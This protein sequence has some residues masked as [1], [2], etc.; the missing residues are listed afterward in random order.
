MAARTLS[1][2]PDDGGLLGKLALERAG[3]GGG[4]GDL[5]ERALERGGL[6]VGPDVGPGQMILERVFEMCG[7]GVEMCGCGGLIFGHPGYTGVGTPTG[8]LGVPFVE[9][10]I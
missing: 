4:L 1:E 3:A 8:G 10:E 5:L 2:P 6:D 9:L 7:S